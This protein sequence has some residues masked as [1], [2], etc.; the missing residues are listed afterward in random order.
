MRLEPHPVV[1]TIPVE[2]MKA[3]IG[4]LINIM[5]FSKLPP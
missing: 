1:G 3:F 4:M 2:E 5:G